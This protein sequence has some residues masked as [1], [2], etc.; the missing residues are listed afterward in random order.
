MKQLKSIVAVV[1]ALTMMFVLA[2]CGSNSFEPVNMAAN[3]EGKGGK[4]SYTYDL[5]KGTVN[6][7]VTDKESTKNAHG[8]GFDPTYG[9]LSFSDLNRDAAKRNSYL[10]TTDTFIYNPVFTS[11]AVKKIN[12]TFPNRSGEAAEDLTYKITAE[13]NKVTQV[14]FG[15]EKYVYE[16]D[17]DNLTQLRMIY[18][19]S[20]DD[21]AY[22]IINY[23]YDGNG[24][25]TSYVDTANSGYNQQTKTEFKVT[26]DAQGRVSAISSEEYGT[27]TYTYNDKDQLIKITS[28][29]GKYDTA[30][31]SNY[32]YD[33]E[34][35][36]TKIEGKSTSLN[37][38][39]TSSVTFAGY[40]AIG[41]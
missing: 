11:G 1:L 2:S 10:V 3:V 30:T 7:S 18:S 38:D 28:E 39:S 20:D 26:Y 9:F 17:K 22:R 5:D 12:F 4:A 19:D 36:L 40:T 8:T 14:D 33:S 37:G 25:I 23:K 6:V 24:R 16:Y 21:Q 31:E 13:D 15:S 34:G 35:N 41:K 32:T 27:T 29:G